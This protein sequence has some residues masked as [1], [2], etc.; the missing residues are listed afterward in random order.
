M[1][2]I[3]LDASIVLAWFIKDEGGDPVMET[4]HTVRHAEGVLVAS[5]WAF[6]VANAFLVAERR[7]RIT[8]ADV[9][10]AI[11]V[12]HQ[13]RVTTD[14]TSELRAGVETLAL[15]RLHALSVYDAAYLELAMRQGAGLATVDKPLR[16]V[17]EQLKVPLLPEKL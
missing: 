3:V 12:L 10:H 14:P 4:R 8:Q 16:A 17:A 9:A 11:A 5:H 13:M 1:K 15:A 2:H 6:E 7:K